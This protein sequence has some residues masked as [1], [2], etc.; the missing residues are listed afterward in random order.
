[1]EFY[2]CEIKHENG[3]IQVALSKSEIVGISDKFLPGPV[4]KGVLGFSLYGGYLYPVVTHSN[5]VGPIFK[6]FLIFP[7][8]AFGVTRVVQEIQGKPTPLSPDIDLNSNE[9]EKLSEYTG[10][11]IIEDKPYYVY[12]IY[13]VHLPVDAKVQKREERVE[14]IKK[15]AMEEFIVIGDAYA[16]T[17]GSVKAI[18][19]SE[20]VTKFKVDNYDGF[21]DYGKIIPVVNLDD[22]NHVV[23][24]ENI[25]YRTSKVL[26]MFGKIL[27]QETTKEKYLETAE[28]TY[29]ILV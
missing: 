17:K 13:N 3:I 22:G 2:V 1:M 25:A 5:I 23:V 28:G 12:N 26:Q 16:L 29:K 10:A 20:F 19:S 4:E 8:F 24:L 18:L 27:I 21:I 9:F 15:D 7:R 6:Y 14:A 11:V